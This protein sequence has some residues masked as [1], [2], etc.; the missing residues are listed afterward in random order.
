MYHPPM[1]ILATFR[2]EA[3]SRGLLGADETVDAAR[4]FA[5]VRDM[6]Y[7]RASSR[8]PQVTAAEWTGTCSG[9]HYLLQAL[10]EKLGLATMLIV[11]TH[12]FTAENSP[13]LPPELLA[14]LDDGPMPDVHQFLRVQSDP[15]TP[16]GGWATVD[17]TWPLAASA[18]GL[19]VNEEWG[20]ARGMQLAADPIELFHTP[21]NIDPQ[22]YKEQLIEREIGDQAAR[23]DR[24]IEAISNWL[25]LSLSS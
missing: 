6:P 4:A 25:D 22:T 7:R 8:D 11:C 19:P 1:P 20:T 10:L 17:A 23:R 21:P 14:H 13:W 9:K 16:D 24:F 18:L 5:L 15:T 12:E 2:D 3:R